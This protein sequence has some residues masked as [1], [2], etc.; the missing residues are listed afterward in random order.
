MIGIIFNPS[1]LYRIIKQRESYEN[2][3]FYYDLAEDNKVDLFFY[4]VKGISGGKEVK[5]YLYQYQ[6]K[7]IISTKIEIPKVNILRTILKGNRMYHNLKKKEQKYNIQF[8]NMTSGRNKFRLYQFLR[9]NENISKYLPDT[10]RLSFKNLIR[11]I[12]EY[13]R[14]IIK[15]I[16]GALGEGISSIEREEGGFLVH[17]SRYENQQER[18]IK[19]NQ[20]YRFYKK[21][22]DKPYLFIVQ[23][24]IPFKTYQGEKFDL[25]TSV[26]KDKEGVWQVTG[27]VSRV[28]SENGIVTNIAQ[29]G[30]AVP[31]KDIYPHLKENIDKK[32]KQLA[33]EIASELEKIYP[34]TADLGLDIAI[35]EDHKLWLIEANYCDER[36]SYRESNDLDMWQA[37]YK[38]PFEYAYAEFSKT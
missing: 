35:D 8:I 10:E 6:T 9:E 3:Q 24:W 15:P 22:F 11:F 27:L 21:F 17:S 25:R 13:N 36:Y 14:V 29:G 4:T 32:I 28:A 18:R 7:K 37:S 2:V 23:R 33:I 26:Q 1:K 38:F 20:L 31:V 16:N 30:R 5:G 19:S 12:K 34:S